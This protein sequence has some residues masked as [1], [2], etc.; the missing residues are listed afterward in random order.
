MTC[1]FPS[2]QESS[3]LQKQNITMENNIITAP[4]ISDVDTLLERWQSLSGNSGKTKD[5]FFRFLT[6]PG[7]PRDNFLA[8]HCTATVRLLGD[9]VIH[10]VI[11]QP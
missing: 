9:V 3:I 1:P 2:L 11:P 4:S 6:T 10:K 8:Q 7:Q 5:D